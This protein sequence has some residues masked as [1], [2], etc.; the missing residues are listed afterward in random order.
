[1]DLNEIMVF[2][3]VVQAASIR[4]AAAQLAMPKSTVS[5]KLSDLE[6]RLEARLIQRTTRKLSLTD[7]GR[8]YYEHCARIMA[9]IEDAEREVRRQQA[10]PSGL[11]R[12]TT[13]LNIAFLGAIL[14]DYLKR[15]PEVRLDVYCTERAVNLVEERFDLAIRTGVLAD[16]TL[17][18]RSLGTIKWIL[19]ATPGYLKKRGRPRSPDDLKQHDCL[20]FGA[21]PSLRL[22]CAKGARSAHELAVP[23]RL[24]V[25]DMDVLH[26]AARE[27]LG[28]ALLPAFLCAKDLSARN[29]ER[30]LS[31]WD[32][33]STP[34]H[35]VYPGRRHVSPTVTSFVDHVR[36]SVTSTPWGLLPGDP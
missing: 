8:A 12:V 16:S 13:P 15:Y 20:L 36:E 3:R 18:A 17:V 23:A 9:E 11:L 22:Q 30:V 2:V 25:T 35:V 4:G 7:V 31:D 14:R 19:V 24:S 29:L 27:G 1:M 10:A 5:R 28:V 26:M 34:V 32:A 6:E 33:P 21:P